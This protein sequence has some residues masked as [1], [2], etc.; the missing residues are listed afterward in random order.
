MVINIE[1]IDR[2][3][4]DTLHRYIERLS[5]FKYVINTR[6][7]LTQMAYSKKFKRNYVYHLD[8]FKN[9]IIVYLYAEP[10]DLEVRFKITG[11]PKLNEGKTLREGIE[12]DLK[13]FQ[14]IS[15]E[16]A[17]RGFIILKYNTTEETPY[18]IAR[19]VISELEYLEKEGIIKV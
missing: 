17:D 13:L 14:D 3:G 4:K 7:I 5:N 1:G 10:E 18:T 8:D 15:H 6:G 2:T 11:E 12:D 9:D 16:L 19:H